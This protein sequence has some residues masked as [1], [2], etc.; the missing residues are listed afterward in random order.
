MSLQDLII[1]EEYRS[2]R[3]SLIE[4]FYL[5][6][7]ENATLYSRAVGFFSSSSLI[8]VSQGLTA[9]IRSGG[10]MRLVASPCLSAEDVEAIATGLK[11][12]E[13]VIAGV[14]VQELEQFEEVA[15]DRLACLAWLLSQGVLEIKLA[16]PKDL[17]HSG[18]YHEKLGIFADNFNIIAFT[19]S[20]NE[21]LAAFS[22]NF[23]CIDTFCS[24]KAN[25][26]RRA[27]RKA[28]NFQRLWENN[29][30]KVEVISFPEAA[31]R[32]LLK[33]CPN[34]PPTK[35]PDLL[36][37]QWRLA[38][39][40]GSYQV[41]PDNAQPEK[42][43]KVELRQLQ[44]DALSAWKK[45]NH[46]GILAMATGAGKTIT[47]LACAASLNDL[48]IVFISV[49]TK[50]LVQQWVQ[51]LAKHT[52]FPTPIQATGRADNWLESLYR[53]L[54]LIQASEVPDRRLP[55][56]CVG[57]Y[58]ELSKLRVADL[59][60]DAGGLSEKSLLVADEVHAAGAKEFRRIL[61]DDFTYR[62]GLSATPI[63]PHD[64]EGTEFLLEYFGGV[65]YEFTLEAAIAAGIL[66]EYEYYV[67]VTSL[68]ETEHE[69]FQQLTKRIG[70]LLHSK[71]EEATDKAQ[72]LKI[73]RAR[74]IKSA[75]SKLTILDR[76]IDDHPPRQG[77]IYCAD[78]DQATEVSARL[79]RRGVRVA[80]YS[81]QDI[82]RT[83]ILSQFARGYLDV[84]IAVKCLDEG[85][86]IPAADWGMILASDTS[87]RQ[88]IQRRGR[89]LRTAPKKAI[90]KLIDILVVPPLGDEQVKLITSEVQRVTHFAQSASNRASVITKLVEELSHYGITSSDLI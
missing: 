45:A 80:R 51:E 20:A 61:R 44:I 63:R 32:S 25:E 84:L 59:F 38:E 10:K 57:I 85:V 40:G 39:P 36:S 26:Q 75:A 83:T 74:I 1:K 5:P 41:D 13:D 35:E 56:I 4:D 70:Y 52:T 78:I 34:Q 8:A 88:F 60:A 28:E 3:C 47:A 30:P 22:D 81:S 23:E 73:Q 31:A 27:L 48:D 33:R 53:K 82:D 76:I 17:S 90:A 7:L 71:D 21:S 43:L 79:A 67:Y 64:E 14:I 29:T 15:G 50:E 42:I 6:C 24:W 54:R 62:L 19:G 69:I 37:K 49:P 66:C 18:I 2:D 89:I 16:M 46:Q 87:Q 72:R 77:M 86:N 9:L 68:S 55:V 11:Q 12:R 65:V 58:S